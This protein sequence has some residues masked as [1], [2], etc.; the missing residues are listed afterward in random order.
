M[1]VCIVSIANL[2]QE[3][4]STTTKQRDRCSLCNCRVYAT[5]TTLSLRRG[6]KSTKRQCRDS[7]GATGKSAILGMRERG[8][9]LKAMP[10]SD[11]TKR[12][13]HPLI[14]NNISVGSTIYT[15]DLLSYDRT[16]RRHKVVNHSAKQYVN[17]MANTNGI[18]SLWAL[19]KRGYNGTYHNWTMKYCQRDAQD[20]LDSLL[21][22]MNGK[23]ITYKS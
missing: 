4:I 12:T 9:K 11:T 1:V 22:R 3:N 5:P 2:S 16:Y 15:N 23:L 18:E 8:G 20:R 10:I 19:L 14:R 6:I 17:G 7:S 13:L 21:S